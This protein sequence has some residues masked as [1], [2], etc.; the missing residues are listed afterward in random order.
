MVINAEENLYHEIEFILM[1]LM[2]LDPTLEGL[3]FGGYIYFLHY[4]K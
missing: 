3:V 2:K 4:F 1:A